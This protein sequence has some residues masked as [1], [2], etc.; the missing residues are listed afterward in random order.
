MERNEL[1]LSITRCPE[2]ALAQAN[3]NHSCA[4]VVGVQE[5]CSGGGYQVPEPWTGH[6]E[7]ALIIFI[8]SIPGIGHH[9]YFPRKDWSDANTIDFFQRR[10]DED[11]G[12]TV[13]ASSEAQ[14]SKVYDGDG[15]LQTA[16]HHVQYWSNVRK[17][18]RVILGRRPIPGTDYALTEMVHCKGPEKYAHKAVSLCST[19]WMTP[20]MEHSG[21]VIV[22]L[23]GSLAQNAAGQLW[24]IDNSPSAQFDAP[25]AGRN[26]AVVILPHP[27]ARQPRKIEYHVSQEEL[28]RLRALLPEK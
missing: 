12:Y 22:V 17:I 20:I 9:E 18:A 1:L 11:A 15:A 3:A 10:F 4:G 28:E 21:A 7:T 24:G 5:G 8:S 6:I 23:L 13:Q 2:L 26:R 14:H 19:K 27:N 16:E 25:I